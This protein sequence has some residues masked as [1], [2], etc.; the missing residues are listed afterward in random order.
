MR[1]ALSSR[2]SRPRTIAFSPDDLGLLARRAE[3]GKPSAL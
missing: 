2:S 3:K 1:S